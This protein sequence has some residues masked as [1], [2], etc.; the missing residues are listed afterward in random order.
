MTL[1]GKVAIVTAAAQGIGRGIALRLAKEGA[2]LVVCDIDM[3]LLN[4]V[5]GEIKALGVKAVGTKTDVTKSA[6]VNQMVK[7]ALDTFGKIDILVNN[8]GGSARER[9]SLFKDSS[10][11]V[12]HSVI[13]RNLFGTMNCCRAVIN[14]MIERRS[15]KI[16]N[17]SSGAAAGGSGGLID[18]S[19]AKAGI[20]AFTKVLAR[21]VADY[22][23]NVNVITPGS[24]GTRALYDTKVGGV[25]L[26]DRP[27]PKT[28]LRARGEPEVAAN[29]VAF[30][31]SDEASY[32]SGQYWE[33]GTL[34]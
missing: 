24:V 9:A 32:V 2:D 1:K 30:L 27:L 29:V 5:V 15:G 7:T 14:H 25:R 34:R 10:E 4:K 13:G 6:E 18:Y 16:V 28:G 23:I 20:V 3:E 11:E 17:M 33:T 19:A 26:I 21:E 31:V 22:G 8:A 12:W